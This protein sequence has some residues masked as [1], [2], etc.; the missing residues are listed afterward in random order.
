MKMVMISYNSAINS[1]VMGVLDKCGVE[2]FT[3]WTQVHGRGRMSGPHF[4]D[5][6]WPGENSVIFTAI[7]NEKLEHLL[8]CVKDLRAK[9]GKEGVKAFVWSLEEVT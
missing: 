7:E 2:N 6:I 8:K 5:E 9:L 3:K 4:G 1:E